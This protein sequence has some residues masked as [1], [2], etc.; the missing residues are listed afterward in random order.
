MAYGNSQVKA[1]AQNER[2]KRTCLRVRYDAFCFLSLGFQFIRV[3]WCQSDRGS[4]LQNLF[5][6]PSAQT[7]AHTELDA[8]AIPWTRVDWL[9][10]A[11]A[12]RLNRLRPSLLEEV[13]PLSGPFIATPGYDSRSSF[14]K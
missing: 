4:L 13:F 2:K 11:H 1:D 8:A 6:G 14:L 5:T 10:E 3:R 7:I 9:T 12:V